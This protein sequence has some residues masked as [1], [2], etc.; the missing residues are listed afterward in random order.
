MTQDPGAAPAK[1]SECHS[2]PPYH[3][4]TCSRRCNCTPRCKSD[5][6][7]LKNLE[8]VR[9]LQVEMQLPGDEQRAPVASAIDRELEADAQRSRFRGSG[10]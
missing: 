10:R 7:H 8:H 5:E 9:R 3:R 1:C 4:R 6:L 2:Y